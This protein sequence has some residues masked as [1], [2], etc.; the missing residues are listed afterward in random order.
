MTNIRSSLA[1]SMANTYVGLPLQII[2]TMIISRLLTPAEAGVYAVAAVFTTFASMFRDFS[3]AEYLIQVKDLD[4][5]KL[6]AALTV[7]IAIS[8]SMS[9]LL[10]ILAPFAAD[11]YRHPGI[12][13]VMKVQC[14]NFLIVPFG[15][16]TMAYFRRD[17][18][19]KP[20][21]VAGLLSSIVTFSVSTLG[22]LHGLAY[23]S[24]AWSSFAGI[25]VTVG[26][27]LWFRP[28]GFPRWPGL[29]GIGPVL[30]FGKFASGIYIFGQFGRGAP[31]MLIGRIH[32]MAEVAL[33][34]RSGGLVELFNRLILAVISPVCQPYLARGQREEGSV[35]NDYLRIM[36]YLT[37]VGWPA[38][39]FLALSS[40][41][42]I[43]ILY[44]SQWVQAAVLA[45]VLCAAAAVD[46][47]H[48][49]SK[50]AL[51]AA[52]DPKRASLLQLTTQTARVI[53]LLAV[54]PFGLQGACWGLFVAA[55][56]SLAISQRVMS[57]SV[58]VHMRPVIESCRLSAVVALGTGLPLSLFYFF[59]PP[60]EHNYLWW[61]VVA[62][63]LALGSWL[64]LLRALS[65]PIWA[66][67]VGF[68]G[69][70]KT[71]LRRRQ[72][73]GLSDAL[74]TE[75]LPALVK[76]SGSATAR[77]ERKI[78]A[79]DNSVIYLAQLSADQADRVAVKCCLVPGTKIFDAPTAQMQFDALTRV[80]GAIQTGHG[81]RQVPSPLFSMPDQGA[82]AMSWVE[83]DSL[84]SLLR[85]WRDSANV[86]SAHEQAGR[87]L[88]RFH[89][90]GPSRMTLPDISENIIHLTKMRL[91]PVSSPLFDDALKAVAGYA[92]RVADLPVATSWLHGDCKPDNFMVTP[93][94]LVGIDISLKY[95][96]AIEN[97]LTA[98]LNELE[99]ML[100]DI[101][102]RRAVP[103]AR[104]LREAFLRGYLSEGAPVSMAVLNWL[105][106]W[107]GL[108]NWHA[109]VVER[110][111]NSPKRWL[112]NRHFSIL[113]ERRLSVMRS[114]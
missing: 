111:T 114:T 80:H 89:R 22:A 3:V 30:H 43:H 98:F 17:L 32:G 54:I 61:I 75:L 81:A 107:S 28:R 79:R 26:V 65:H 90:A 39:L 69:K 40:F 86:I 45:P 49:L 58:G 44:G 38:L 70:L 96:N 71:L 10:F 112:L 84:S 13:L 56:V 113:V 31:E 2:G 15:A 51:L 110:K 11:F 23:M 88:A 9:A 64:V 92:S 83:G 42:A 60:G 48:Y 85:S 5:A 101:R 16:V 24:L 76:Q 18:N 36:A 55:L 66:E 34:S 94:G 46:L 37:A 20:I 104:R 19:F 25:V 8:W 33:F 53:G 63:V 27:A 106:L 105:Q 1:F 52:G 29:D 108:T 93:S 91:H 74:V 72:D 82:Y 109:A 35:V 6:R 102:W 57:T 78:S 73:A 97:D 68:A 4:A 100:L 95:E 47:V 12:A 50:E 21:F 59:V 62:A 87:W 67:L 41:P 7:N 77:V 103:Y 14:L 99:L